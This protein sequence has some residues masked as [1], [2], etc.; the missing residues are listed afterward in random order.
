MKNNSDDKGEGVKFE[1]ITS[2]AHLPSQVKD[3]V[4]RAMTQEALKYALSTN[5]NHHC[6]L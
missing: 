5:I 3:N 2:C 6:F 1:K 4:I